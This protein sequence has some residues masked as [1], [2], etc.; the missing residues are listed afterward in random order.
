[1]VVP[2]GTAWTVPWQAAAALAGTDVTLAPSLGVHARIPADQPAV[3]SITAVIDEN[4]P[5]AEV[6]EDALLDVR[7]RGFDVRLPRSLGA[8]PAGDLLLT[9]MHGGG[10]G[11]DFTTG[12]A[13]RP[14]PAL[15]LASSRFRSVLA[16][17]CW[18]SAAPPTAYPLNLPAALLLN[19]ASTVAGGLW[20][21]PAADTAA[22]VAA[23][24]TDIADGA[25]LR[26]A[27]RRAREKAPP[28]VMSRWGLA[29]HGG[30]ASP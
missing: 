27:I 25:G 4:A 28:A 18:S 9:F 21:L 3:G 14:L 24:V 10:I 20:P 17:A 29:V 1:M 6:V 23:V 8:A 2:D 11:L 30:P 26:A 12:S 7:A 22:I 5:Y 16:A 15:V 13:E 19:G